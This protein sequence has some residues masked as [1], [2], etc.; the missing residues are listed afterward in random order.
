M[1]E[2]TEHAGTHN[3]LSEGIFE[4]IHNLSAYTLQILIFY[5]WNMQVTLYFP[6]FSYYLV[7]SEGIFWRAKNE[8]VLQM[9][10]L[11]PNFQ[12]L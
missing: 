9:S 6:L 1:T 5:M 8:K 7:V 11:S 2:V 4:K 10:T 12:L 3:V